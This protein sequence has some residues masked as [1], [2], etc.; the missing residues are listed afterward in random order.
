MPA[1]GVTKC[2]HIEEVDEKI[3]GNTKGCKE[4][5]KIGASWV[6]LRL[7]LT[8]GHVEC[9][10]SSV[11]T[12]GTKHFNQTKRPVIKSYEPG[13]KWKWCYVDEVFIK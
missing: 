4:S 6:H 9:C 7:C 5:E 12:H 13:E 10:D 8:C 3:S 11:N 2:I 1:K